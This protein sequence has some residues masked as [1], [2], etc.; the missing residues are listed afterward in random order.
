[1]FYEILGPLLRLSGKGILARGHYPRDDAFVQKELRRVSLLLTR[2]G[3][4]WPAL[5]CGIDAESRVLRPAAARVCERLETHGLP[6]PSR[7]GDPVERD[8][9]AERRRLLEILDDA[10]VTL[11][12]CGEAWRDEALAEVRRALGEAAA[13]QLEVI[14]GHLPSPES[15]QG[16]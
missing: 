4:A 13:I 15:G 16:E 2:V 7:S 8:A 3:T 9:L 14:D 1:M 5:F 6:V 11:H 10:I 12:G